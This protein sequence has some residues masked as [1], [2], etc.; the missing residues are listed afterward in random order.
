MNNTDVTSNVT[1]RQSLSIPP[2]SSNLISIPLKAPV[3]PGSLYTV[4]LQYADQGAAESVAGGRLG[5]THYPI[6]AWPKSH[7][8]PFP[9]VEDDNYKVHIRVLVTD[10]SLIISC[11]HIC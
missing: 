3:V 2:F 5:K 4:V 9:T 6:E 1:N 11:I 7:E 8:C 10:I